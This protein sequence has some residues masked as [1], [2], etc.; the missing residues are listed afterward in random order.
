MDF[1]SS[2]DQ[3]IEFGT[4]LGNLRKFWQWRPKKKSLWLISGNKRAGFTSTCSS[5]GHIYLW[6]IRG[7]NLRK[8]K[9]RMTRLAWN[10][11]KKGVLAGSATASGSAVE[12]LITDTVLKRNLAKRSHLPQIC[13]L[14][15]S[16]KSNY[17]ISSHGFAVG[18]REK[19]SLKI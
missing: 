8:L 13:K 2:P 16:S 6:D 12:M 7:K 19:N 4:L 3:K 10:P 14:A 1:Q 11:H 18:D 9:G 5:S 15:Y 17:L